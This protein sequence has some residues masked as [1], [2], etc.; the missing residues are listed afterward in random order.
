VQWEELH[1]EAQ[2]E[3]VPVDEM[4]VADVGGSG[5]PMVNP[6]N[7]FLGSPLV[8]V[9]H[10]PLNFCLFVFELVRSEM[11]VCLT[12]IDKS[13]SFLPVSVKVWREHR[14][15][16]NFLNRSGSDSG[17]RLEWWEGVLAIL[18]SGCKQPEGGIQGI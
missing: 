11:E 4:G 16:I 17:C 15:E 8:H 5:F 13:L 18:G 6:V 14:S 3:V 12:G 10:C 9:G 1:P 2:A 7:P